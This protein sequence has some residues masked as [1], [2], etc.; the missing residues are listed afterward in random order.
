[1]KKNISIILAIALMFS[2]LCS[3]VCANASEKNSQ[4]ITQITKLDSYFDGP[5]AIKWKKVEN[6]KGYQI[7]YATNKNFKNSKRI[8]IDNP[9]KGAKK[10]SLKVCKKYYFRIRTYKKG[11]YYPWSE[12]KMFYSH[13]MPTGNSGK[14]F[15]SREEVDA[16]V[17]AEGEELFKQY[18]DGLF[19]WEEYNQK[20]GY[21]YEAWDCYICH[22][23][24][25]NIKYDNEKGGRLYD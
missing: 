8:K 12:T 23:F 21:G 11:K 2:T 5:F 19:T 10:L 16:Y 9:K 18:Q 7:E 3:T 20:V 17:R 1:M 4:Y 13:H 6:I 22:K 15:N 14:W 25:L 24:T